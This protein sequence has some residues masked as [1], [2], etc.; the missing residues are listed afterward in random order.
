[1][2][3]RTLILVMRERLKDLFLS[4]IMTADE[5]ARKE[6]LRKYKEE[7]EKIMKRADESDY[8]T[9]D[10]KDFKMY[11]SVNSYILEAGGYNVAEMS[12]EEK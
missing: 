4:L 7:S 3:P 12:E 8:D 2:F 5:A 10:E 11:E 1:M 9:I 6:I